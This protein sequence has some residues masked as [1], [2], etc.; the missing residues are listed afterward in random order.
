MALPSPTSTEVEHA[1][2][3][4]STY[5]FRVRATDGA[6]NVSA[7]ASSSSA[8]L[9]VAQETGIKVAYA[10]TWTR[11]ALTGSSGGYVKYSSAAGARSLFSF[12]GT[13]AVL[14]ATT[15]PARGIADIYIDGAK[16]G[17]VDFYSATLRKKQIAWA[18]GTRLSPGNHVLELRVTGQRNSASSSSRV[19]IDA[20]V[21]WP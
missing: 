16:V 6:G 21:S 11:G 19:D 9:K 18:L 20:F 1:L 13:N 4:G 10:G 17:T 7:W 2:T 15:G 8:K 3:P 5:R 12:N 14:V